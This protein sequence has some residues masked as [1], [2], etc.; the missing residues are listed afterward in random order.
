LCELVVAVHV[1][2]LL[3][4]PCGDR[5]RRVGEPPKAAHDRTPGEV[6]DTADQEDG[7]EEAGEQA[8]LEGALVG[9]ELAARGRGDEHLARASFEPHCERAIVAPIDRARPERARSG[10]RRVD[11]QQ[12]VVA[13]DPGARPETCEERAIDR[14][15]RDDG[16]LTVRSDDRDAP[17]PGR[18]GQ[19]A[20][21]RTGGQLDPHRRRG[22]QRSGDPGPVSVTHG[23]LEPLVPRNRARRQLGLA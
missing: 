13:G 19:R 2:P 14:H 1:D 12:P 15:A 17:S 20:D 21:G 11:E 6:G 8:R 5:V 9:G 16:R 23:A 10:L 22:R 3:E 18:R 4:P 7:G